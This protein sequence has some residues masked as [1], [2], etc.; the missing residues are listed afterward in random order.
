M[1]GTLR[2]VRTLLPLL[3]LSACTGGGSLDGDPTPAPPTEPEEV[4]FETDDGL[5]LAGTWQEAPGAL[6]GPAALLLHQV[7][8]P[9]GEEHD[10]HDF[11]GL[12]EDLLLA[13]VSVLAFDFRS[14][15]ASD[16]ATAPLVDLAG[17]R[18]QLP[19]DVQAG[20]DFVED[21]TRPVDPD[22]IG[23]VGLGLGASLAVV[24]IHES[25]DD[26]PPD[27]GARSAVA[28]GARGDRAA[29]LNVDGTPVDNLAL[30]HVM[31]IAGADHPEDAPDAQLLY[32]ETRDTR[33]LVL[34]PGTALHGA[35]LL[36]S[37]PAA[38]DA[39]L[40]WFT[41]LWTPEDS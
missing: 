11:D 36:D 21:Q 15:G 33:E 30:H 20:L 37:E 8:Q 24:A 2:S 19:L 39:V 41:T 27:W 5:T 17:R 4:L 26:F 3:I 6:R 12:R 40:D 22:A 14:H 31:Y 1:R 9:N 38:A 7:M 28:I 23:V 10:R 18:D 25:Y 29:D 34:I 35:D 32:D 13:G 16:P